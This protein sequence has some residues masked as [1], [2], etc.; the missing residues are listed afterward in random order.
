M[1]KSLKEIGLEIELARVV[2]RRLVLGAKIAVERNK[3]KLAVYQLEKDELVTR[4]SALKEELASL[5]QF[6]ETDVEL[7]KITGPDRVSGEASGK[8]LN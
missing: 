5:V 7:K 4:E 8:R 2:T 1:A 3:N 6:K